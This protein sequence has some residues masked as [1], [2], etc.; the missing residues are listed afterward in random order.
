MINVEFDPAFDKSA[1]TINDLG[2][3]G[4]PSEP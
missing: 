1:T 3:V 4:G 2:W